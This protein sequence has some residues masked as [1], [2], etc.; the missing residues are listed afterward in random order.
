MINT[1]KLLKIM[2]KSF[3]NH[4]SKYNNYKTIISNYNSNYNNEIYFNNNKKI[5]T[6]KKTEYNLPCLYIEN[7]RCQE[8]VRHKKLIV[9]FTINIII[10]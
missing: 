5:F 8:Q 2:I 1:T 9:I 3:N 6:S 10:I 4:N 7:L